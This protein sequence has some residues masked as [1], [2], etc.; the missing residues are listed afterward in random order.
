[1]NPYFIGF[2]VPAAV[3][4]L[5][6]KRRNVGRKRGVPVEVGGEPGYTIGSNSPL[7]HTGRG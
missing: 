1:M 2:L 3:S 6:C 4:L 7:R 5:L